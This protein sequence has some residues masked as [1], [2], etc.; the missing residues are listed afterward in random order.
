MKDGGHYDGQQL[1]PGEINYGNVTLERAMRQADSTRLRAWL[2]QVAA[3]WADGGQ[4]G[5][6]QGTTVTITLFSSVGR[7]SDQE[8]ATW[9]LQNVIPVSWSGPVLSSKGGD[10]AIEKLTFAHRGFLLAENAGAPPAGA[11]SHA[12]P[13]MCKLTCG[14]DAIQF[15]YNPAKVELAKTAQIKTGKIMILADKADQQVTDPTKLTIKLNGIW[16]EGQAAVAATVPKLWDWLEPTSATGSTAGGGAA[17]E[18]QPKVL[19][20]Q[21]GAGDGSLDLT[22]LLKAVGVSYTRFSAASLPSRALVSLSLERA[23]STNQPSPT[24]GGAPDSSAHVLTQG[25]SLPQVANDTCGSP[26]AWRDVAT[27]NNVDD[28]LKVSNGQTMHLPGSR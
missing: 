28:P 15:Q 24:A 2:R 16:I 17:T 9:E 14:S 3:E 6:P 1:L 23:P 25:E 5:T 26:D 27:S 8:V 18:N 4:E 22:C 20:L 7:S 12:R 10:V 13:G 11:Q 21:M 19:H